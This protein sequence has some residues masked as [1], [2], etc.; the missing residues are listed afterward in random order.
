MKFSNP[1]IR[2]DAP[3]SAR[4]VRWP[5][6]IMEWTFAGDFSDRRFFKNSKSEELYWLR[7]E[8]ITRYNLLRVK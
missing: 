1:L 5:L 8:V 3:Q 6:G 4:P 7:V 2:R